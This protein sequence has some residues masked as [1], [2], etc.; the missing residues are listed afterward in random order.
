M[1]NFAPN[2]VHVKPYHFFKHTGDI[3]AP[4]GLAKRDNDGGKHKPGL[5]YTPRQKKSPS[6]KGTVKKLKKKDS[7]TSSSSS[8]SES[9]NDES[10]G[11]VDEKKETVDDNK[12][13]EDVKSDAKEPEKEK[14]PEQRV[15]DDLDLSDSDASN[16][17]PATTNGQKESR[18]DN[19]SKKN[20]GDS[21]EDDLVDPEDPDDYLLFLEDILKTLHKAFYDLYDQYKSDSKV[22]APDLKTVIPYV[23]RKVLCGVVIVFSGVIPTQVVKELS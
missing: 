3:N 23:K 18:D 13:N 22:P 20:E 1:W 9:E 19:V 12:V 4:P 15:S 17:R 10:E 11:N 5:T 21:K 2:L 14:S 6:F 8:S 16:S 7:E